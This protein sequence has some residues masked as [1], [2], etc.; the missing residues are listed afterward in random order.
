MT[1]TI[2]GTCATDRAAR[3]GKQLASH[4]GRK[5]Q[6][7]E[8]ADGWRL[9]LMAGEATLTAT[10]D[11]LV[12]TASAPDRDGLLTAMFVLE[13]HLVRF[14]E[15]DELVVHWPGLENA[16][17]YAELLERRRAEREARKA[18]EKAASAP[19]EA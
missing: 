16:Q 6:V 12:M 15:R 11:A 14:G 1:M 13:S 8:T 4:L 19:A 10:P 5:V 18:A 9:A 2:T 7:T 3:Y 17:E